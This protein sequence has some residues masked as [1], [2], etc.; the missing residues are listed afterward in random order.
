[1]IDCHQRNEEGIEE[2]YLVASDETHRAPNAR[3]RLRV[4]LCQKA[5][6]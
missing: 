2:H 6:G 3:S 1:M 5:Q 4:N